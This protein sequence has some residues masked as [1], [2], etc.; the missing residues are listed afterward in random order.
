MGMRGG[1]ESGVLRP[2]VQMIR[3]TRLA[4]A[5]LIIP[6]FAA[7][8]W[9][10][11]PRGSWPRVLICLAFVVLLYLAGAALLRGVSI[12]LTPDGLTER[13]FFRHHNR[14]PAK[15]IATVLVLDVYRGTSSDT[16]RQLFLLDT[17]G[18]LLL[19]MRGEFW[20]TADL[21]T[22]ADAFGVPV[23]QPDDPITPAALRRE[24][25]ELLYW[26]ERWP[27][28]GRIAIVGAMALLALILI[29]LMLPTVLLTTP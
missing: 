6:V 10:A 19:R 4:A 9:F 8:L 29:V 13:G 2:R 11:I 3:Q 26:F 17:A 28:I 24:H 22:V 14:V 23:R 1:R 7:L 20:S 16:T 21:Q 12:R 25:P 15:R 27:W 18:A 5:A